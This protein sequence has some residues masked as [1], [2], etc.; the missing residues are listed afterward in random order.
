MNPG[1]LRLDDVL[2]MSRL[3]IPV[4]LVILSG[5]LLIALIGTNFYMNRE[6][7][8]GAD[9]LVAE[10]RYIENLR[11][12][13]AAEKAFGDLKYRLTDAAVSLLNLPEQRA[14]EA[15][16]RLEDQL[17]VLEP[18]DTATVSAIRKEIAQLMTRALEAVNAYAED[19]RVIGNT[20]MAQARV[21]MSAVDGNLAQLIAKLRSEA[22]RASA[23]ARQRTADAVGISWGIVVSASL[24]ALALT[25]LILRSIVVPL[26]SLTESMRALTS[27][28]TD[29]DIPPGGQ[30]ELGHMARTLAMFREGSP[31]SSPRRG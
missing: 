1:W 20:L 14:R 22:A 11:T 2:R 25:V 17:T 5:A 16:A 18:H 19:R 6:M 28:R 26:G 15:R 13:S 7:K 29:I 27:G 3:S 23:A 30:D 12:A 31:P 24:L 9:A 21:H 8:L 4:R 10:S